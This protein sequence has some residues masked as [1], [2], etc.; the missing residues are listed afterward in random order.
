M[1]KLLVVIWVLAGCLLAPAAD[2]V[3][4]VAQNPVPPNSFGEVSVVV[5]K[6]DQVAYQIFPTPT[7]KVQ[8]GGRLFLNGPPGTKYTVLVT[9]VNF[10]DDGGKKRFD[11]GQVDVTISGEAPPLPP[12]P[13]P[14]DVNPD[15]IDIFATTLATQLRN[16]YKNDPVE[17]KMLLPGLALVYAKAGR[18][19]ETAA[20]WGE[21]FEAMSKEAEAQKVAGK[22]LFTQ[23]AI[24]T[25]LVKN[26]PSKEAMKLPIDAAGR[27]TAKNVFNVVATALGK[28]K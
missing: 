5:E 16:G 22:L 15:L 20:T 14:P 10:G 23:E 11:T 26:L 27:K 21:L 9:V 6:G 24:Q 8:D 4:A 17:E 3:P 19:S 28:V 12:A 13:P 2:V 18:M 1:R 25:Y 7:K